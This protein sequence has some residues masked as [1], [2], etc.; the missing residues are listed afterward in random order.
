MVDL[1]ISGVVV[2]CGYV[3]CLKLKPDNQAK[4]N[5]A[6]LNG[7]EKKSRNVFFDVLIEVENSL[8]SLPELVA[9]GYL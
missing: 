4:M 2:L 1:G 7:L 3:A 9:D 6:S 8:V 5:I